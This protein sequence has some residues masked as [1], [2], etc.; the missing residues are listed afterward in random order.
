MSEQD[1]RTIDSDDE[2]ERVTRVIKFMDAKGQEQAVKILPHSDEGK[3]EAL[4]ASIFQYH[5]NIVTV[6]SISLWEDRIL[7]NMEWIPCTLLSHLMERAEALR[8]PGGRRTLRKTKPDHLTGRRGLVFSDRTVRDML[9]QII[10]AARVLHRSGIIHK[11]I[12]L[13]NILYQEG[14]LKLCD[15]GFAKSYV[16]GYRTLRDN[17][18]SRHYSS[19]EIYFQTL[20][21]G[22]EV[23]VWAIGV[24]GYL[25]STGCFPFPGH[26]AEEVLTNIESMRDQGQGCFSKAIKSRR[27]SHL[28]SLMLDF[29]QNERISIREALQHPFLSV[30]AL[31]SI[32]PSSSLSPSSYGSSS[33]SSSP[34]FS[35]SSSSFSNSS[36]RSIP[37]FVYLSPSHSPSTRRSSPKRS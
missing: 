37:S 19:P 1:T 10:Q 17:L 7:I 32:R 21:E 22:P 4:I 25:L 33:S 3:W 31:D 30:N 16:K 5:P 35:S 8:S 36:S 2:E 27:L 6:H 29:D 13:E 18:G 24:C 34:S 28:L 20:Y 9:I 12:K 11:D 15:F 14:N 26:T 23:D